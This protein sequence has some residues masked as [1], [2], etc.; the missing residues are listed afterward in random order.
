[1]RTHP[2]SKTSYIGRYM[3]GYLLNEEKGMKIKELKYNLLIKVSIYRMK[4][5]GEK[6]LCYVGTTGTIPSEYEECELLDAQAIPK[7]NYVELYI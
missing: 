5:N 4:E 7:G 3:Y 2:L 6:G 1:M